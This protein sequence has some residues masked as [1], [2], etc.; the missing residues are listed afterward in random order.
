M[1]RMNLL[2]AELR[3][4]D[5]SRRGASYFVVGAL[6]AAIVAMLAYGYVLSGVRSDESELASL[7]ADTEVARAQVEALGPYAEF[8][9]MKD[10][11]ARSVRGVAQTRFD[12][13]RLARELA[14]ILPEGVSVSHLDVGPGEP[15]KEEA[16]KGADNPDA[17]HTG[18]PTMHVSGCAPDQDV[19]AD[20]LDRLRALTSATGVTLGSSGV[21][22]GGSTGGDGPR[23][24]SG[25]SGGCI[26]DSTVSFDA[27]V[28]LTAPGATTGGAGS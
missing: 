2:P 22:G 20:T 18:P 28:T 26:G 24:V 16:A 17:E 8:A 27:T 5:G 3:P 7:Q 4:R 19:V 13:E 1:K 11:R 12:Y 23:L 15:S 25:P 6:G 9:A 21:A 14:R 10:T